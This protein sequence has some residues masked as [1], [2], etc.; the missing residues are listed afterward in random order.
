MTLTPLPLVVVDG[1]CLIEN[2]INSTTDAQ[3][4]APLEK[5]NTDHFT[6]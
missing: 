4:H 6:I 1:T 3:S 5:H 2:R